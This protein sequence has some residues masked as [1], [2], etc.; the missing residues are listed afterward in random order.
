M[1][2]GIQV[3]LPFAQE[4]TENYVVD[5]TTAEEQSQLEMTVKEEE[6]EQTLGAA[7]EDEENEHSVECLDTFSQEAE[8]V[9]ALELTA[10]EE[11]EGKEESEHSEEWLKAFSFEAEETAT[12]EFAA[13][14]EEENEHSEEWL[15]IFSRE[16]EN[17]AARELAAANEED[18]DSICFVD[19]WEQI[20][21]MEEMV[22]VQGRHIQQVK[23]EIDQEGMGDHSDLPNGLNF[24]QLRRLQQQ[25]QPLEQLDEVIEEIMELMLKSADTASEEKLGREKAAKEITSSRETAD[26]VHTGQ[27][28]GKED[29]AKEVF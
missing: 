9:V 26:G 6:L 29:Q 28:S 14:A 17:T 19:L 27:A 3:F 21:S 25:N 23:L 10:E 15:D 13:G 12:W 8:S 18:T 7:Q 22:K 20:E 5:D 1:I 11:A 16:T 2:G 24:L 4:E